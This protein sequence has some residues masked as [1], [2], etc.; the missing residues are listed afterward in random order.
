MEDEA[1][2]SL[3]EALRIEPVRA[4]SSKYLSNLE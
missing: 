3:S 2:L 4:T 1:M